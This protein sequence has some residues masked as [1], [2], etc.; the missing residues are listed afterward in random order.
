MTSSS[1]SSAVEALRAATTE[2]TLERARK[3]LTSAN[4]NI[5]KRGLRSLIVACVAGACD[6]KTTAK[7]PEVLGLVLALAVRGRDDED[8]YEEDED[9]DDVDYEPVE[10]LTHAGASSD[11]RSLAATCSS[12]SAATF[13]TWLCERE[14]TARVWLKE[15]GAEEKLRGKRDETTNAKVVVDAR[16][17]LRG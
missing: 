7:T 17:C 8:D 11:G 1:T 14:P 12:W 5:R 16:E 2:A 10:A 3:S 15:L 4:V 6:A 9:D 13:L